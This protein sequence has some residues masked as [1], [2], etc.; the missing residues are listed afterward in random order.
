MPEN[1]RYLAGGLAID[2]RGALSF[3]NDFDMSSIRRFYT[4]TNH[5][6]NFIRA[7]H[8]HKNEAKFV[9]VCSG[10]IFIQTVEIDN[11]DN[12]SLD[13]KKTRHVLDARR[14]GLLHIPGGHAHGFMTLAQDTVVMF[15][16]TSSLNESN[17]DDYRYPYSYWGPWEIEYR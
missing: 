2:D 17:Q 5:Q 6:N 9:F 16:S 7:W 3:C 10:S 15:F 4:V 14:P 13:A 8:A 1:V 11:W 12:P